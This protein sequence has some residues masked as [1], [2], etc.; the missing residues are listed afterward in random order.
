VRL[1]ALAGAGS[2]PEPHADPAHLTQRS[3]NSGRLG[4]QF[5]LERGKDNWRT[6]ATGSFKL[7]KGVAAAVFRGRKGKYRAVNSFDGNATFAADT[8]NW[9]YFTITR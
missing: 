7:K 6:V 8:S 5:Q 9:R 2:G 3:G 1:H 4:F